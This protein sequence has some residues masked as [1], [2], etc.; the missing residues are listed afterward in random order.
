MHLYF[1]GSVLC[2]AGRLCII[3]RAAFF[4]NIPIS[5]STRKCSSASVVSFSIMYPHSVFFFH[6]GICAAILARACASTARHASLYGHNVFQYSPSQE[7]RCRIFMQPAFD[8][9]RHI[10]TTPGQSGRCFRRLRLFEQAFN[11]GRMNNIIQKL[12][13]TLFSAAIRSAED[14]RIAWTGF[15]LPV[16]VVLFSPKTH[17]ESFFRSILP[18][19]SSM[20]LTERRISKLS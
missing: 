17:S 18:D 11:H 2:L 6:C 5:S 13:T 16:T 10:S 9:Q 14:G 20:P 3:F 19:S 12:H 1:C 8:K 4:C 15:I 7:S